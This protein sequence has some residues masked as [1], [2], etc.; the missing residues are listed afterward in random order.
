M[1]SVMSAA[2]SGLAAAGAPWLAEGVALVWVAE[3]ALGALV[4]GSGTRNLLWLLALCEMTNRRYGR[5]VL[6]EAGLPRGRPRRP[7]PSADLLSFLFTI[8]IQ[9][10]VS[11]FSS[12]ISAG[13]ECT[14][15]HHRYIHRDCPLKRLKTANTKR[16]TRMQDTRFYRMLN[17]ETLRRTGGLNAS[18]SDPNNQKWVLFANQ[19]ATCK[20]KRE[21]FS[22]L[23]A[24]GH[25]HR[26]RTGPEFLPVKV[27]AG[28]VQRA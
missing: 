6:V 4:G 26:S 12:V 19:V 14:T 8:N 1:V 5:C 25:H 13:H 17:C 20:K 11:P 16:P 2:W 7:A 27:T 23:G 10:R 15:L 24:S 22:G 3:R 21:F 18:K 9:T 28:V